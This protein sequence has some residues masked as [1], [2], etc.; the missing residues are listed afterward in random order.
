MAGRRSVG[1][2]VRPVARVASITM[3]MTYLPGKVA[4]DVVVGRSILSQTVSRCRAVAQ[5]PQ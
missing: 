5:R 1:L 2:A 3:R 4:P